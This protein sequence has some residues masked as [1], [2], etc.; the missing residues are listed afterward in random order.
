MV[1]HADRGRT[2]GPTGAAPALARDPHGAGAAVF[3]GHG[4]MEL[5]GLEPPTS[6]VRSRHSPPLNRVL[7]RHFQS[8]AAPTPARNFAQI[9]RV[10][11]EIG[12]KKQL[13]GPI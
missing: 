10:P 11:G 5:G 12:P 7:C 6:W 3:P 1:E 8:P 13:F 2:D 4:L 9:P